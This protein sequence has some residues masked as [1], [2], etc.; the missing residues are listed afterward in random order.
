M[1]ISSN[2]GD[3]DIV[4]ERTAREREVNRWWLTA[5][6]IFSPSRCFACGDRQGILLSDAVIAQPSL[7]R[8]NASCILALTTHNL[9]QSSSFQTTESIHRKKQQKRM[10]GQAA[11]SLSTLPIELAY[12]ILNH[13]QPYNI[14]LSAYSV[15]TRWNSIIDTYQ[16]YQVKLPPSHLR[17]LSFVLPFLHYYFCIFHAL[18]STYMLSDPNGFGFLSLS[19]WSWKDRIS[20][21]IAWAIDNAIPINTGAWCRINRTITADPSKGTWP[22]FWQAF[23]I[24]EWKPHCTSFKEEYAIWMMNIFYLS[25]CRSLTCL[26]HADRHQV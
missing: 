23:Y 20:F 5:N 7:N 14:L 11:P 16:P 10:S 22:Y 2:R 26:V 9:T 24:S 4:I 6:N 19:I 17:N 12:R 8:K 15:C 25:S 13:F 21:S 1:T 3:R 18:D